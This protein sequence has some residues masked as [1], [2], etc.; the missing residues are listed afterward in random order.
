MALTVGELTAITHRFIMPK[1]YDAIFD[2][3]PLLQR[4]LK[5]GQYH[6]QDGGRTI[7]IP[8]NYAQIS[9]SDW[10]EGAETLN[11][12]E[13]EAITAASY[14]WK[15]LYT[16]ITVTEEDE[17]K[18]SGKEGVLKILASKAQIAE[19]T[20]K[21]KLGTGIYSDGT[22][23]KSVIGLRD[24]VA[25]DQT[26]GGIDQTTNTFW[27]GQ[28]DST[29]TVLSL[30]TINTLYENSSVDSEKPT[31]IYSTRTLYTKY[32]NLLQPQ[33]RFVDS[34]TA[35]GGFQNL[36]FNGISWI[37]DSHCPTAHVFGIN[38]KHLFLFY[39]PQRNFSLQ[40]Y[41][42]PTNQ[43]VKIGRIL[44]MGALASSNNRYHFKASTLT[45]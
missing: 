31:A 44:W 14:A 38:E 10:Y 21:D 12:A 25:V 42:K 19:K 3:N 28:V 16:T 27:Q 32:Y 34:D 1:M 30:G 40:P 24:I 17:L 8:L 45:A 22:N 26:V 5:S 7:D 18:N 23:S 4:I 11:T 20:I 15:S 41:Q 35:K 2:S 33:Q 39:H 13:N 37:S 6:S 36:M 43:E 29:S 9:A